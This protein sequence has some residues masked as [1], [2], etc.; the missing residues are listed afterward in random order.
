MRKTICMTAVI[1]AAVSAFAD[2]VART[3]R[4]SLVRAVPSALSRIRRHAGDNSLA[5]YGPGES[6]HWAVQMNQQVATALAILADEPEGELSAAGVSARELS[7]T[8]LALFR[9]SLRTHATGD[10]NCTDGRKWG[11]TWIS[12]LGLERSVAGEYLLEPRFTADDLARLKALLVEESRFRLK[13]Y[14]VKAGVF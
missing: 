1:L 8:A 2:D 6:G 10:L 11:R 3:C 14:P 5:Y 4:D 9:Y 12:V 7:D 13:E